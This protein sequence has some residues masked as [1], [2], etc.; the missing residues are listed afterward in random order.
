[1]ARRRISDA[2][3]LAQIPAARARDAQDRKQGR[4]ATSARYDRRAERIVLEL[5]NGFLF[6]FPV[7]A[8]PE[9]RR[10]TL[11]QLASVAVNRGGSALRWDALD[12]DLSVAGL[13]LSA[14]GSDERQRNVA[15]MLGQATSETKAATSRANGAKGGRPRKTASVVRPVQRLPRP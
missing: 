9:L 1:M 6:A 8:I 14:V 7:R 3:I 13:L 5:T 15:R 12:V 10:A 2:E 11:V 4:R